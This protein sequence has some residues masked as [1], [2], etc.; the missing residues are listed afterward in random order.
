MQSNQ[1]IWSL[2]ERRLH[3]WGMQDLTASVLEAFGPLT[4]LGAQA[5]HLS[6][7]VLSLAIPENHLSALAGMLENKDET[8]AFIGLLRKAAP[9]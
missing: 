9:D 7:P 5:V 8:L 2:W 6:Q 4:I 3:R 1:H